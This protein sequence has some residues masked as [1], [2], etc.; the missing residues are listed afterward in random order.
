[1]PTIS[2]QQYFIKV[3]YSLFIEFIYL[4]SY[5]L[6]LLLISLG[7]LDDDPGHAAV[8]KDEGQVDK[9]GFPHLYHKAFLV[10]STIAACSRLF[11]FNQQSSWLFRYKKVN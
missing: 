11:Q 6:N 1:M 2:V 7:D 8:L 10:N 5:F 3:P 9:L 4:F